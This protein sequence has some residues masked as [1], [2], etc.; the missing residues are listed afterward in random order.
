[1][2]ASNKKVI[3][4]PQGHL[5]SPEDGESALEVFGIETTGEF[6]CHRPGWT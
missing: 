2:S 6:N 1:M 3:T 5:P 4:M